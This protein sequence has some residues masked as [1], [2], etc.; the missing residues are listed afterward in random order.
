MSNWNL[1]QLRDISIRQ[2]ELSCGHVEFSSTCA[3]LN[4]KEISD[5]WR[6]YCVVN[7]SGTCWGY[8]V[9]PANLWL[10]TR[11]CNE[12]SP[13]SHQSSLLLYLNGRT[14]KLVDLQNWM[15]EW[16]NVT[17]PIERWRIRECDNVKPEYSISNICVGLDVPWRA[18]IIK[19]Q[20]RV[21]FLS[22]SEI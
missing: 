11:N 21:R 14:T 19:L 16:V 10:S 7:L 15:R 3:Q 5:I 17:W 4:L 12:K 13:L 8:S 18:K 9:A 6:G 2:I 1:S 20:H 22:E